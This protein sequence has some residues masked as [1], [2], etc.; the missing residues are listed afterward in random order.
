[1]LAGII[2]AVSNNQLGIAGLGSVPV[3]PIDP[4]APVDIPVIKVSAIKCNDLINR[5]TASLAAA[6]MVYAATQQARIINASWH[7][8]TRASSTM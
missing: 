8:L 1:M 7:V 2:A 4:R 6:G 5:P 3:T